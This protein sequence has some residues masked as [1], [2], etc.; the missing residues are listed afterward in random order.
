MPATKT[1]E[2]EARAHRAL[3]RLEQEVDKLGRISR[4]LREL[5]GVNGT[6]EATEIARAKLVR[7]N[8][9]DRS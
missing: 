8:Q 6:N 2:L 5:T 1:D 4:Q 9:S 7:D 3:D